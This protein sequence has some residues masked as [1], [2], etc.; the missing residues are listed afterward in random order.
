MRHLWS[1][2]LESLAL[3]N[4]HK[5]E[6]DSD[7]DTWGVSDPAGG[8]LAA[9]AKR[10]RGRSRPVTCSD[11]NSPAV[12]G[13]RMRRPYASDTRRGKHPATQAVASLELRE[14][15]LQVFADLM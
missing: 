8:L 2:D 4:A 15:W 10:G 13:G 11:N 12:T 1:P 9:F 6:F 3:D 7:T 14:L 5:R